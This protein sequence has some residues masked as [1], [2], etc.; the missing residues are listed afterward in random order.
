MT[1]LVEGSHKPTLSGREAIAVAP[2]LA[3]FLGLALHEIL[4]NPTWVGDDTDDGAYLL[5]SRNIWHFGAP[6]LNQSG[7]AHWSSTW[8][9]AISILFAPFGAL[10]MGPSVVAERIAV[11]FLGVAFLLLGYVWMRHQLGLS[12]IQAG[13]ATI[14]VAGTYALARNGALVLSD[15]PAAAA[16]MGGI[17]FL[18]RDRTRAGFGLLVLSALLRP[19]NVAALAAAV[20]WILLRQRPRAALLVGAVGAISGAIIVV[21]VAV[22][23]G[24]GYFSQ[25]AHPGAGGIPRTLVEQAKGLSW[26]PLGWFS[27]PTPHGAA[28]IPLKLLSLGLLGL[29]AFVAHRRRLHLEAMIVT[30]TIIVL[31]VYRTTGAGDARYLIPFSPLFVGAIFVAFDLRRRVDG[32]ACRDRCC[33]HRRRSPRL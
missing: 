6:L 14:C 7:S 30:A 2:A 12:R 26:Y 3:L 18:R 31:L 32:L 25:I 8:S 29:V 22:G 5:M 23:G 28:R 1:W 13:L 16:L 21:A 19:I 33:R 24:G 4:L 10:P 17:V 15:V 27:I 11:M 20:V 9:P